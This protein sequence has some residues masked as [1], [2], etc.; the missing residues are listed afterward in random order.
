MKKYLRPYFSSILVRHFV[1]PLLL[2]LIVGIALSTSLLLY[3]RSEQNNLQLA[4]EQKLAERAMDAKLNQMAENLISYSLWPDLV[5]NSVLTP[6][7]EWLDINIGDFIYDTYSYEYSYVV[8]DSGKTT[9]ASYLGD[10]KD[11]DVR[12]ALGV[13]FDKI[14]NEVRPLAEDKDSKRFAIGSIDGKPVIFAMGK[15]TPDTTEIEMKN[16]MASLERSYLVFAKTIDGAVLKDIEN[17]YGLNKLRYG[18]ANN[19][20]F[21]LEAKNGKTV[22]R[23]SWDVKEPGSQV[24][25]EMLPLLACMLLVMIVGAALVVRQARIALTAADTSAMQLITTDEAARANLEETIKQVRVENEKLNAENLADREANRKEIATMRMQAAEQFRQVV[26]EALQRLHGAAFEL[27]TASSDMRQSSSATLNQITVAE[28]AVTTA[29]NDIREVLP[30][31]RELERMAEQSADGA[32]SALGAVSTA[33]NKARESVEQ[34]NL[35]SQAFANIDGFNGKIGDIAKQTNLLAL[36]ATIEAARAGDAGRGFAVVASEVKSLA[37]QSAE[38]TA[39]VNEE[40]ALLSHQMQNSINAVSSL[41][42]NISTIVEVAQT[43]TGFAEIQENSIRLVDDLVEAAA[44]E[45]AAATSAIVSITR[46][47]SENDRAAVRVAE[48]ANRLSDRAADL[49]NQVDNFLKVL[50]E[51]A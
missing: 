42:S 15:I 22:G 38:L 51:A 4:Q 17:G 30:T 14:L 23:L 21:A 11:M 9:Y 48:V 5:E 33:Q 36:N 28:K 44:K 32:N 29:M 34:I 18:D 2:I 26:S 27:G 39:L 40:T 7:T 31:T 50:E 45:G 41:T 6:N 10:K 3:A 49:Q 25:S 46:S 1:M 37:S 16:R 12:K 20:L 13:D 19:G 47:A 35:L 24:F 8:T 43:I